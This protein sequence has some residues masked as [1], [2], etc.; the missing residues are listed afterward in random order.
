MWNIIYR[1]VDL[2]ETECQIGKTAKCKM[3]KNPFIYNAPVIRDDF[4]N[5]EEVIG[6][7]LKETVN[8]PSQGNVWIY[9]KGKVGKT[10]LLKFIQYNAENY[11]KEI[12]VYKD[13]DQESKKSKVVYIYSNCQGFKT[14]NDF[15]RNL[16]NSTTS[17]L[18]LKN[19]PHKSW[20]ANFIMVLKYAYSK[21]Y[22]IVFLLDEFDAFFQ[23][24]INT[25]PHESS[26]FLGK[27]NALTQGISEITFEQKV[28][29]CVFSA[30][31]V[32][33]YFLDLEDIKI[34]GSGLGY[35][36]IQFP[37]FTLEQTSQLSKFY[38]SHSPIKFDKKEIKF[39]YKLTKGYPYLTQKLFSIM[40]DK[41]RENK[42]N[43]K[44][45][46]AIKKE[47]EKEFDAIIKEFKN[48]KEQ[49]GILE[50]PLETVTDIGATVIKKII[51][52]E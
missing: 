37:W 17:F 46:A 5:R 28:F 8:G 23:N 36:N 1:I 14:T 42:D 48:T 39:C 45:L 19:E 12:L 20:Y 2:G 3:K 52:N 31:C 27:L 24:L 33:K 4:F 44:Y 32:M 29:G 35:E 30:N 40:Y 7:I 50:N 22:Y 6:K 34:A 9:G 11:N 49:E 10:S 43:L 13:R 18:K 16:Y 15:Y 41:K 25:D 47:Y 38:L 21:S 26:A 51:Q